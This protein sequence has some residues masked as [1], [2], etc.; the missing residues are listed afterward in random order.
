MRNIKSLLVTALAL[1]TAASLTGQVINLPL[2]PGASGR[3]M[4]NN[5]PEHLGGGNISGVEN[6]NDTGDAIVGDNPGNNFNFSLIIGFD[7]TAAFRT[8]VA[9]GAPVIFSGMSLF[10]VDDGFGGVDVKSTGNVDWAPISAS[11]NAVGSATDAPYGDSNN[12]RRHAAFNLGDG[13][14]AADN[15]AVAGPLVFAG[16][17]YA[18]ST[19]FSVDM[20]SVFAGLPL[21][22]DNSRVMIGIS[23]W[24]PDLS[25]ILSANSIG[26]RVAFV[27]SSMELTAIP[28]PSTYAA[29]FG[30]FAIAGVMLRR[31]LRR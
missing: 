16:N 11:V 2:N 6:L 3:I 18:E 26:D 28:E 19:S 29:I 27:G 9:G 22:D 17:P 13:A 31:R 4:S 20:T 15:Y 8:A 7:T 12:F 10:G 5:G 25:A 30:L 24:T 21:S 14:S 1:G 23:A